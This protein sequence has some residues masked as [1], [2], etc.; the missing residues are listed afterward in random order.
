MSVPNSIDLA[1]AF[2]RLDRALDSRR[3]ILPRIDG[4]DIV[5]VRHAAGRV[6]WESPRSQLDL[7]P[8]DKSAMDGFALLPND[9]GQPAPA[10]FDSELGPCYRVLELVPAG[11]QGHCTLRPGST[12][13]VMTGAQ[14]PA[15]AA[16]VVQHEH[17]VERD[18]WVQVQR[19]SSA[20]NI[21]R[22]GED[23]ER[24]LALLAPGRRLSVLDIANL[25]GCGVERV[26]VAPPLRLAI[27]STG[28]ELVDSARD[29]GPGMI[30]NSNGPMLAGLAAAYG[31]DVVHE[32]TVGDSEQAT[33]AALRRALS[34]AD[35]VVLS[36]GVSAGD[37]DLVPH[38]LRACGLELL[39]QQV[40]VKPGKPVTCAAGPDG[41]VLGLPGNPVPVFLMFHLFVLRA[42]SA[43]TGQPWP[44]R[45]LE[46][47]L[48][49]DIE[50]R[51]RDRLEYMPARLRGDGSLE[52]VPFHGSA[53]LMALA[54]A[55]GFLEVPA[56]VARLA[57][58]ERVDFL[59]LND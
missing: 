23:V 54:E 5:A 3:A 16:R 26:R 9:P 46:L 2:E 10:G 34:A 17:T 58:G 11:H 25:I 30:L 18:G 50:R 42:L 56:G 14:V 45:R 21:C 27:L 7:P 41:L 33:V 1:E 35:L 49:E 40:A 47:P 43:L 4:G 19:D 37:F 38:A 12:I 36:G 28:D 39:F 44:L 53:H 55:D 31:L 52:R 57:A 15:G 8:F 6:L 13:K 20:P 32:E 51:R 29:L 59:L 48:S 22:Q 24:G